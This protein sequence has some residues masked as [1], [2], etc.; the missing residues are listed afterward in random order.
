MALE[1]VLRQPREATI[2]TLDRERTRA[3]RPDHAV[4]PEVDALAVRRLGLKADPEAGLVGLPVRL[5]FEALRRRRRRH[6]LLDLR[7]LRRLRWPRLA[8]GDRQREPAQGVPAQHDRAVGEHTGHAGRHRDLPASVT[9][10]RPR[11]HLRVQ[12]RRIDDHGPP[13]DRDILGA[14]E[15]R[16]HRRRVIR[17]QQQ[18]TAIGRQRGEHR[19]HR[20]GRTR[21]PALD[22]VPIA[23]VRE[24]DDSQ[25]Q[26]RRTAAQAMDTPR[27]GAHELGGALQQPGGR[28]ER[29]RGRDHVHARL[30]RGAGAPPRGPGPGHL[31]VGHAQQPAARATLRHED[32]AAAGQRDTAVPRLRPGA[33]MNRVEQA[34]EHDAE[35]PRAAPDV[36]P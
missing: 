10:A 9:V 34:F 13:V 16:E 28:V 33:A 23:I 29:R 17:R 1:P 5:Q 20:P 31:R 24:I 25:V 26:A 15:R 14:P 12:G 6:A 18:L 30:S 35:V 27:L 19:V 7:R 22:H 32:G 2:D 36:M 8:H 21:D 11:D 3:P 4:G